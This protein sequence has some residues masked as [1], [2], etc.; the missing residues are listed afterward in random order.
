MQITQVEKKVSVIWPGLDGLPDEL[1]GA[2]AVALLVLDEA[3]QMQR[4]GVRGVGLQNLLVERFGQR[5]TA[6]LVLPDGHL[7][8][9]RNKCLAGARARRLRRVFTLAAVL[10]FLAAA[11]GAGV[12][13]VDGCH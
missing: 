4:V 8:R 7:Q 9:A 11:A 5:Q 1:N 12:V 2:R 13:A 3:Q 10:V 6:A